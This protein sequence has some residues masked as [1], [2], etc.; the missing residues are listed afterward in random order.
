MICSVHFLKI[1]F[2]S[3]K[4]YK[5]KKTIYKSNLIYTEKPL[6]KQPKSQKIDQKNV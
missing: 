1:I 6:K 4:I 3:A 5:N 2:N